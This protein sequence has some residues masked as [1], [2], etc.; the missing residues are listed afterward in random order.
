MLRLLSLLAGRFYGNP[1]DL[2]DQ[3]IQSTH[4]SLISTPFSLTL[5]FPSF[6]TS[7]ARSISKILLLPHFSQSIYHFLF[8]LSFFL[9]SLSFPYQTLPQIIPLSVLFLLSSFHICFQDRPANHR[10]LC[11]PLSVL[12]LVPFDGCLCLF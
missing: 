6:F 11:V 10:Y 12:F 8:S 5:L 3:M 1:S 7:F 4:L 2:S 9:T